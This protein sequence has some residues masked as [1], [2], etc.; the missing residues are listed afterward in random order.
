MKKFLKSIKLFLKK[1]LI[2][3]K[4]ISK[5]CPNETRWVYIMIMVDTFF[6][7]IL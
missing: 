1:I 7:N 5:N 6:V 3:L 2:E 4:E